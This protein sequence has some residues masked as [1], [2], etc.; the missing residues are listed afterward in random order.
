MPE[1]SKAAQSN[2]FILLYA[3]AW[4]GGA[5][6]YTPFLTI[7]LPVRI[8]VL[9][10]AGS[11]I[12]WL[13]YVAFSGAIAASVGNIAFGYLS[14]I[15]G[16]RRG[17][18]TLGMALSCTLL[19]V[20]SAART[21]PQLIAA[22]VL[23]Q[24]SLNM[25][26]APLAAWAADRVPDHQK[27]L[28]GGMLAFA[29]GLA[30]L[31]G[32]V[33]THPGLAGSTG[34]LVLVAL[35]VMSCVAPALVIR[36]AAANGSTR[37]ETLP[38]QMPATFGKMW[39]AR[40]AIQVSEAA[41][42]SYLYFWFRAIDPTMSENQAARVLSVVLV[43][44][45]PAALFAGR[46]ADRTNRP[47]FPL[48]ACAIFSAVGL[49]A[50]ALAGDVDQAIGAYGLF[51]LASSVFLALHSAQTMRVLPRSDRRG[52]D[53]GVLNL[54]NTVPSLL[55]PWITIMVVPLFGFSGLFALLAAL[56]AGAGLLLAVATPKG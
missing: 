34:R 8:S 10:G 29:P 39:L 28:L 13:A 40:L 11:D 25:M 56:A 36:S 24:L 17:W 30:G 32:A 23:W 53:L 41:M 35:A 5:V 4:A 42:F 50:M 12:A 22:V 3:L 33:V 15:T 55:M 49:L 6:A 7:L 46:W 37:T 2:R 47:L 31:F 51:G 1:A 18:I 43:M 54:T 16:N 45:A 27:G 38:V 9:A 26:L 20:T 48:I 19:I 52:R 21:L 14:D 44:S